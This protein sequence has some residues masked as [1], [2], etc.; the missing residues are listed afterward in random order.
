MPPEPKKSEKQDITQRSFN[1]SIFQSIKCFA[2]YIS[3]CFT[4]VHLKIDNANSCY[5]PSLLQQGLSSIASVFKSY[6]RNALDHQ[7][8]IVL[9]TM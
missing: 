3:N 8:R 9:F 7:E 2:I 4:S 5:G 1:R 6:P